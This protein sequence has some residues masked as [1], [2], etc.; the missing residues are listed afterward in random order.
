MFVLH[1]SSQWT[2]QDPQGDQRGSGVFAGSGMFP[3]RCSAPQ[4][5]RWMK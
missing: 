5:G 3:R 4:A 2:D 1:R